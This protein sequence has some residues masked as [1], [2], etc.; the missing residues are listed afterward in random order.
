MQKVVDVDEADDAVRTTKKRTALAHRSAGEKRLG[1][2]D[3]RVEDSED[4]ARDLKSG[5]RKRSK[6]VRTAESAIPV[7][8]WIPQRAT[9]VEGK[10][11][12]TKGK[13]EKRREKEREREMLFITHIRTDL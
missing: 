5:P 2:S 9:K 1:P 10:R 8:S 13:K 7:E 11:D 12:M 6:N 3:N 4:W